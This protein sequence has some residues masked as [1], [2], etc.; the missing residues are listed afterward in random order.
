MIVSVHPSNLYLLPAAKAM[1]LFFITK[2]FAGVMLMPFQI[3]IVLLVCGTVLLWLKRGRLVAQ[4]LVSVGLVLL[5]IFS[6][7]IFAYHLVHG[8]E[9]IYPPLQLGPGSERAPAIQQ[10]PA[11]DSLAASAPALGQHPYIVVLSGGASDDPS[12]PVSFRATSD[13]AFRVVEAVEIYRSFTSSITVAP[14]PSQEPKSSAVAMPRIL[15]SGGPTLNSVPEAVPM[16]QL[17]ESL[18][19]PASAILMET[20]SDD[21]ASEAQS[22]LPFVRHKPFILVTSA[23]HMPRAM[24]LFRHL[25]MRPVPA[26]SNYLGVRN[27]EPFVMN[28]T[29]DADALMQSDRTLHERVGMLWEHLRGQL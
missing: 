3:S 2:K 27:T 14:N 16:Q 25:G 10:S 5:L 24:A 19:I 29:P 20:H 4:C 8:L 13:S 28:L 7:K 21:T 23:F 26:P 22:V 1:R 12:L 15:I 9:A 6:N 17:A 18:G 11:E